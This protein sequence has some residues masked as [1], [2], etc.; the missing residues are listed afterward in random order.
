MANISSAVQNDRE[1][2]GHNEAAA[3]ARSMFLWTVALPGLRSG[4]W[5]GYGGAGAGVYRLGRRAFMGKAEGEA[6][7]KVAATA[8]RISGIGAL[9]ET[10]RLS[11]TRTIPK[12]TLKKIGFWR[13]TKGFRTTR[14][15]VMQKAFQKI[16][17]SRA[18]G[19]ALT[20]LNRVFVGAML[21]Q[22]WRAY[23][24]YATRV[25]LNRGF[26]TGGYFP[27]S[28]GAI[29]SRQRAIRAISESRLQARSAVGNEAQLL[30]R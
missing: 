29:T 19:F 14:S 22:G 8:A 28:R 13:A 26:E 5:Q 25:A 15:P 1:A 24:K 12:E 9:P 16:A 2:R 21:Y 10:L 7:K 6:A 4:P 27:E 11:A 23:D 17:I 3:I 20:A 30:H 18:A